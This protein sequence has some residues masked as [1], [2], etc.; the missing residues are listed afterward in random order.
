[1]PAG[2]I[3]ESGRI[4][5][6]SSNGTLVVTASDRFLAISNKGDMTFDQSQITGTGQMSSGSISNGFGDIEN[7]S[8]FRGVG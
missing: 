1:M 2:G 8:W 4:V 3:S 6:P 7:V 5:L